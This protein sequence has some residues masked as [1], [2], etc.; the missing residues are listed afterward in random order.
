MF[1]VSV[2]TLYSE[3]KIALGAYNTLY[4]I[5]LTLCPVNV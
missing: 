1:S 2:E 4:A 5:I 3:L